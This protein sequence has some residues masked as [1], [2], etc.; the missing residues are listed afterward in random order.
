MKSTNLHFYSHKIK[1]VFSLKQRQNPQYSLR[2][3]AR[4]I[5][6]HSSTLSQILKGRR[7]L[8]LKVASV[9]VK[10]LGLGPKERTLFMESLH[11]R[12]TKIDK[13]KISEHDERFMLDESYFRTI[14]EWEHFAIYTL[15]DL[16][17]F[18]PTVENFSL[19]LGITLQRAEVVVNNLLSCGLLAYD[20]HGALCKSFT[21]LRTTEDINSQALILSHLETLD[22]GK[23]KLEEVYVDLR[24][25]SS[26]TIA[27]D[28]EKLPELKTIIREFRQ[29]VSAL[30]KDGKKT[31]VF[32]MAIQLYPMTSN[33]E[34]TK[35][36]GK[37]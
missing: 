25:F 3:Y 14:A 32:Q 8:P 5:G 12:K 30:V 34:I 24:D 21:N 11:Q 1:E 36:R 4:D 20:H 18:T 10:K 19:K 23:K 13:I 16:D 27:M 33:N 29:K 26:L 6:L 28:L 35:K 22:M 2:A 9:V 7:P 31:E 37:K 15:F 17:H